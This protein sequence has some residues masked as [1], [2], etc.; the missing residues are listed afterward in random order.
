MSGFRP[1][2]SEGAAMAGT[3]GGPSHRTRTRRARQPT[4][5]PLKK[6]GWQVRRSVADAVREAVERG[7][8]ESQNALVEPALVRE[9]RE[10]RRQRIYDAYAQAAAD[11]G[12]V[13]DMGSTTTAWEGAS[14]D[15][16][17]QGEG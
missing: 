13:E 17:P 3:R 9:L 14:G 2:R 8:A 1:L 4:T 7:A 16:L 5:H 10:L 15:G 6:V 11:P 12:F